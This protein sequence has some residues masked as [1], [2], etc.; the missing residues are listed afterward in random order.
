MSSAS[1]T[2]QTEH[3]AVEYDTVD[4]DYCESTVVPAE[5]VD[6]V[7]GEEINSWSRHSDG[8]YPAHTGVA[9]AGGGRLPETRK[10]CSACVKS[11]F[12]YEGDVGSN[13]ISVGGAEIGPDWVMAFALLGMVFIMGIVM[14][15]LI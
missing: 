4:C 7:I 3:G 12:D 6:I 9:A 13:T 8:D 2:V 14:G 1:Q 15:G 10:L 11:I 5:S